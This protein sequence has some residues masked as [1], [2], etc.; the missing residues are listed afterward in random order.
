MNALRFAS[1]CFV[2]TA[3]CLLTSCNESTEKKDSETVVTDT[4]SEMSAATPTSSIVSSPQLMV[5][6]KH[7]V[8]DYAKWKTSYDEHDSLRLA[9]GMHSYVIGRSLEDSNMLLVALK[10]DDMAR[11]KAFLKDPS[12]KAAMQKGGVTGNPVPVLANIVWQDTASLT[13][14]RSML[15][16]NVKDWTAWQK[17][18]EEGRAERLQNGVADR[19][20]GYEV[21]NQNKVVLVTAITDTAKAHAYWTSD[22]LKNRRAASGVIGTPERFTFQI[23]QRY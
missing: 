10:A 14:I 4:S 22:M 11:A 3:G 21:D 7:R 13:A 5:M 9:N 19:V 23:V 2:I 12:L 20:Y 17:A 8:R 18:F 1:V 16:I 6:V 15:T